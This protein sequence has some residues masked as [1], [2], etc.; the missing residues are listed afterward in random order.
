[1]T[2]SVAGMEDGHIAGAVALQRKCFPPPFPEELLWREEHLRRHLEVFPDGQFAAVQ[3]DGGSVGRVVGSASAVLISES[4]WQAHADWDTTVGGPFFEAFD[5][6]GTTLYAADISVDPEWRG[7]G[8]GR[9]LY[10]ARKELVR[11]RGWKRIGT[12]C[13]IPDFAAW[14]ADR[15]G[16]DVAD[17]V[18][19][20][21]AGAASDRTLTPL[22]RIGMRCL[23]VLRNYMA[24]AES[25]DAA[26]LLE[27]TP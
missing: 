11:K 23:G 10:E 2:F 21:A 7:R 16:A 13:R 5:P 17:Y 18:E 25:G 22:L 9:A 1:M 27:W 6:G 14:A 19:A 12:A 24:D 26:A 15:A 20:V 3:A 4:G 8:V